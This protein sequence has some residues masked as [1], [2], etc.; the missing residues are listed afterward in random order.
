MPNPSIYLHSRP[1]F[2][3]C[4]CSGTIGLTHQDC[5]KSWLQFKR[6]NGRCELCDT[7]FQFAPKYADG[8]PEILPPWEVV[9]G[10][11]RRVAIRWLPF[12]LRALFAASLWLLVLPLTTLYLYQGWLHRPSSISQRWKLELLIGDCIS[13]FVVTSVIIISFLC[14]MSFADFLRFHWQQE[15]R[16][17]DN[18]GER[19]QQD[20]DEQQEDIGLDQIMGADNI[21]DG[22]GINDDES[23][24]AAAQKEEHNSSMIAS[25]K[26]FSSGS[27]KEHYASSYLDD[28]IFT[29]TDRDESNQIETLG[30]ETNTAAAVKRQRQRDVLQRQIFDGIDFGDALNDD[31]FKELHPN[32][33]TMIETSNSLDNDQ[34]AEVKMEVHVPDDTENEDDILEMMRLQEEEEEQDRLHREQ[35]AEGL[36]DPLIPENIQMNNDNVQDRED[37]NRFEPQFE[38]LNPVAEP[39]DPMVRQGLFILTMCPLFF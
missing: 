13:G 6:G 8:A 3:P 28:P 5:L 37:N 36:R 17:R 16:Q 31:E 1:L 33:D 14:L 18:Q 30:I 19:N 29:S 20:E 25:N 4:K 7:K 23:L 32:S 21:I 26:N 34:K 35:H 39:E 10:L 15:G 12:A 2:K 27:L 38:P 9:A 24:S 11:A 22:S